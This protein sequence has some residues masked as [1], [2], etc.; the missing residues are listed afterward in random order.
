MRKISKAFREIFLG[1]GNKL[2]LGKNEVSNDELM[3]KFIG[4]K[5]SLPFLIF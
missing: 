1:S 2:F 5:K 4:K 3:K